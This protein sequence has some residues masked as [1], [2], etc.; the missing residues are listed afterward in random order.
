MKQRILKRF[1]KKKNRVQLLFGNK[2]DLLAYKIRV[3]K[4]DYLFAE[5]VLKR[6]SYKKKFWKNAA[7]NSN[8]EHQ[9]WCVNFIK[10]ALQLYIKIKLK[11][12]NLYK[13]DAFFWHRFFIRTPLRDC[14][15][16]YRNTEYIFSWKF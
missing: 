10:A 7:N 14:F 16:V 3:F 1:K 8:R 2:E 15:C 9:C 5:K 13:F 12:S 4:L 6:C 11:Q